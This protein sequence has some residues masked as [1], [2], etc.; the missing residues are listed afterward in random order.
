MSEVIFLYHE[1]ISDIESYFSHPRIEF[2][3]SQLDFSILGNGNHVF[4]WKRI[5]WYLKIF[6]DMGRSISDIKKQFSNVGKQSLIS[7][8]RKINSWYQKITFEYRNIPRF[9]LYWN[10]ANL[11]NAA[12]WWMVPIIINISTYIS[13]SFT[14]Q[15]PHFDLFKC[16]DMPTRKQRHLNF[17]YWKIIFWYQNITDFW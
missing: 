15:K 16:Q 2:L 6:S 5:V 11:K 17:W 10:I 3:I 13:T 4:L 12:S 8:F 1:I 9:L 14:P 7:D